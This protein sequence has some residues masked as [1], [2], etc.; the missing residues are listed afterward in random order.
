MYGLVGSGRSEIARA[1]FGET[2]SQSGHIYYKNEEITGANTKDV[3]NK[4]IFYVPE[5]R[6]SQGLFFDHT[7][8]ENISVSFLDELSN[9][10]GF[11]NKRKERS[12]VQANIEQYNI[13]TPSQDVMINSLSGGSQQKVL[14]C[15]W[16]LEEPEV[17]ILDEPTRGIDVMTKSEI[18]KYIMDL[19]MKNVAVILISSDLP[20]VLALSDEILTLRKG[21]ITGNFK[22]NEATEERILKYSLGLADEVVLES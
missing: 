8:T 14:F 1:I 3:V 20:E 18:H 16:L 5:D 9:R 19:A 4:H 10:L 7:I 12:I 15:R 22:R 17:L 11:I 2:N 21:K 13:K 6:G